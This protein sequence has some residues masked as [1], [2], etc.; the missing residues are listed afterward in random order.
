MSENVSN[1]DVMSLAELAMKVLGL[2]LT[3]WLSHAV[4]KPRA[5]ELITEYTAAI[6]AQAIDETLERCAKFVE[7]H[8]F[9]THNNIVRKKTRVNARGVLTH[10]NRLARHMRITLKTGGSHD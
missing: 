8:Y 10:N 1:P 2:E 9:N 4:P 7:E 3:R 5:I 6:R